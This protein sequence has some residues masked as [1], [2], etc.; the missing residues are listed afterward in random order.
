[1]EYRVSI[2]EICIIYGQFYSVRNILKTFSQEELENKKTFMKLLDSVYGILGKDYAIRG[3]TRHFRNTMRKIRKNIP[4]IID[5]LL[6][7]VSVQFLRTLSEFYLWQLV[8]SW[9]NTYKSVKFISHNIPFFPEFC[10]NEYRNILVN[11]YAYSSLDVI[12]FVKNRVCKSYQID[13]I[14]FL[15][16]F[17]NPNMKVFKQVFLYNKHKL[18]NLYSQIRVY[19]ICDIIYSRKIPSKYIIKKI[20]YLESLLSFPNSFVG[21]LFNGLFH[22]DIAKW[23]CLKIPIYPLSDIIVYRLLART[24]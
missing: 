24:I 19:Q 1:M 12:K 2:I 7:S 15:H 3:K 6:K 21:K 4:A 16:A 9:P 11:C 23:L 18:D 20:N 13:N 22:H 10:M 8:V 17:R 5:I 14:C